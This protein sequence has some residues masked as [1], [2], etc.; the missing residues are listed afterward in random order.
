MMILKIR[1]FTVNQTN[2]LLILTFFI[3]AIPGNAINVSIKYAL[4]LILI[5]FIVVINK[6]I[7]L[8]DNRKIF[9]S[10]KI[11]NI[12]D[13]AIY[14]YIFGI[15]LGGIINNAFSLSLIYSFLFLFR[16]IALKTLTK[17][18][19]L[20]NILDSAVIGVTILNIIG[21]IFNKNAQNL[22][23]RVF[24]F[25]LGG[26]A[27]TRLKFWDQNPGNLG[28]SVG[29]IVSYII[30]R[31]LIDQYDLCN[32]EKKD[33]GYFDFNSNIGYLIF[34]INLLTL[35]LTNTRSAYLCILLGNLPIMIKVFFSNF[36]KKNKYNKFYLLLIIGIGFNFKKFFALLSNFV[37]LQN[38]RYRGFSSGLTGRFDIW[39]DKIQ[40]LGPIG[41]G[42]IFELFDNNYLYST[43]LS[44]FLFSFPIFIVY[45]YLC[46]KYLS[47]FFNVTKNNL[48]SFEFCVKTPL[49]VFILV[50]LFFTQQ[51]IGMTS[52]IGYFFQI[53][54]LGILS[55]KEMRL[56]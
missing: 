38:D 45:F 31:I 13:I 22:L 9:S 20:I 15:I 11:R 19:D 56:K 26:I 29:L 46:I 54:P 6:D 12:F 27:S 49:Q 17:K 34:F 33:K 10:L 1:N 2:I 52:V 51:S 55:N 50:N 41:Y 16:Q 44:G 18:V 28:V 32:S 35:F 40:I 47:S 25:S 23:V 37:L 42:Y 14:M 7:N 8:L 24:S 39:N 36:L 43:Y 3:N 48:L 21:F 4:S 30:T 53:V 5:I